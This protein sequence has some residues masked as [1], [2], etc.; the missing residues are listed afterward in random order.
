MAPV[1]VLRSPSML[2]P[3]ALRAI[4]APIET[5]TPVVP[6]PPTLSAKEEMVAAMPEVLLAERSTA[7]SAFNTLLSPKARARLSTTF[8]AYAPAPLTAIPVVPPRPRASEVA[9]ALALIVLPDTLRLL[10]STVRV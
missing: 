5:P 9:D 4:A 8:C 2:T 10:P 3:I 6:P 7:P 1:G